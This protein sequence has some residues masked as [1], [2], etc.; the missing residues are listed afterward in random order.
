MSIVL[1]GISILAG[2]AAGTFFAAR[3]SSELK[4]LDELYPAL[5]ALRVQ[6]CTYSSG[7]GKAI[8]DEELDKKC[9]FFASIAQCL[10]SYDGSLSDCINSSG[11]NSEIKTSLLRSFDAVMHS[12]EADI[13]KSLDVTL[14]T[15]KKYRDAELAKKE[16]NSPL[17]KKAGLLLG[18]GAAILF[19]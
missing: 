12:D 5:E 9:T 16:K 17:Y 14:R 10:S 7:L 3:I 13:R 4:S 19:I 11:Y 1:G 6:I 15:V 2:F 8:A 18:I